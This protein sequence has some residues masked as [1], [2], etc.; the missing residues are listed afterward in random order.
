M[1]HP[2]DD[3]ESQVTCYHHYPHHLDNDHLSLLLASV[4]LWGRRLHLI[5]RLAPKHVKEAT[6][7]DSGESLGSEMDDYNK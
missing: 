5:W 2:G 1:G 7:E 4:L 6:A 3:T